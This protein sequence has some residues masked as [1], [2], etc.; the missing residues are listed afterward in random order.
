VAIMEFH[1]QCGA[2]CGHYSQQHYHQVMPADT[3]LVKKA[4][5]FPKWTFGAAFA[6]KNFNNI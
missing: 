6:P 1:P 2:L 4:I 3:I 5:T